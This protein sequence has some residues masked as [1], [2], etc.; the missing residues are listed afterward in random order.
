MAA[1]D[2]TVL[3]DRI[4]AVLQVVLGV[5]PDE[6]ERLRGGLPVDARDQG[7]ACTRSAPNAHASRTP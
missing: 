3:A 2:D 7:L 6:Y 1:A 4:R 5:T